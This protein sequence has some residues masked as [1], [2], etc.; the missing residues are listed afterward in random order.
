MSQMRF[1]REAKSRVYRRSSALAV[2]K[3]SLQ[4][5]PQYAQRFGKCRVA[6]SPRALCQWGIIATNWAVIR[7]FNGCSAKTNPKSFCRAQS[8]EATKSHGGWIGRTLYISH[9]KKRKIWVWVA[10]CRETRR[11]L[12]WEVGCRGVKTLK[13]L[14][15][16]LKLFETQVYCSDHWKVYRAVLPIGRLVQSKAETYTAEQTWSDLRHWLARFKRRGKVVSRSL[17]DMKQAIALHFHRVN[18]KN[19]IG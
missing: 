1:F 4:V 2:Q 19:L 18:S 17:A 15:E 16:R 11:I 13:R 3:L 7:R 8:A 9:P 10:V 12:D 6:F 14:W 5:Y